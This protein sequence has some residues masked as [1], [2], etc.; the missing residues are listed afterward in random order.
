MARNNSLKRLTLS[1]NQGLSSEGL[2]SFFHTFCDTTSIE[3]IR[4]SNHTLQTI[5]MLLNLGMPGHQGGTGTKA[6]DAVTLWLRGNKSNDKE[7]AIRQK[8]INFYFK[9]ESGGPRDFDVSPL[10]N[11]SVSVLPEVINLVEGNKLEK[12]NAI[13]RFVQR[14][15]AMCSFKSAEA[16]I[17][18]RPKACPEPDVEEHQPKPIVRPWRHPHHR[19]S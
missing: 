8:I 7:Y 2:D 11:L 19:R 18:S 9:N 3:S 17:Q 15:S 6:C 14:N 13:F 10:A 1:R 5:Y 12:T 16:K 4:Q